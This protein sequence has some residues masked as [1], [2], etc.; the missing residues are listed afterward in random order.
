MIAMKAARTARARLRSSAWVKVNRRRLINTYSHS[1]NRFFHGTIRGGHFQSHSQGANVNPKILK[2][3]EWS[4]A[5][6]LSALVLFLLGIRAT[7][8][9]ALWRDECDSLELARLPAFADIV[10]NLKFTSF[11][12]LFPAT[13]RVFTSLFGTSDA[14]LR[15]FG[16]LIGAALL[17][18]AWFNTRS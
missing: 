18:V 17:A 15:C 4:V 10:H 11:P 8:A 5:I 2:Y 12:I 6:L 13:V 3:A 16:F 14:S 1:R 7:H 9:G